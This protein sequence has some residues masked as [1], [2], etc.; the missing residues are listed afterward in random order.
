MWAWSRV[1]GMLVRAADSQVTPQHFVQLSS[2]FASPCKTHSSAFLSFSPS[3]EEHDFKRFYPTRRERSKSLPLN[4]GNAFKKRDAEF[5]FHYAC[6]VVTTKAKMADPSPWLL[7][8][9]RLHDPSC[10]RF[11]QIQVALNARMATVWGNTDV[12]CYF[13]TKHSWRGK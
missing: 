2:W 7:E 9:G 11:A 4:S 10:L 12:A 6:A 5:Y 8:E 3:A 1:P 13:T